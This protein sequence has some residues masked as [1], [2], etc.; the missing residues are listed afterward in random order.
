MLIGY[1]RV[2][3]ADQ[4]LDLQKDALQKVGC[5]RIFEEKISGAKSNRP[6]LSK[7]LEML[8]PGD[9]LAV[10]KLD[11]L[12][13]SVKD[14]VNLVTDLLDKGIQFRSITDSIDTSTPS[15]RFFFNIMASLSQMERELMIE[16]T[17]AGL[18]AARKAGRIGG[19]K[20]SMT[21]GKLDSARKLLASGM[22]PKDVATSLGIS[23]PTLYRWVPAAGGLDN[24]TIAL[25]A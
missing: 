11:R 7:L 16:R 19:R 8:R 23:V 14:L 3:T 20:R 13:R 18:T 10:W 21:D 15:G 2:S 22:P 9:T 1:A 24:S 12:G 5:D 4:N 25:V 6:E 17:N